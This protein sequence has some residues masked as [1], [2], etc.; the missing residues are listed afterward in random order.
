MHLDLYQGVDR[1]DVGSR[2]AHC[3]GEF[4]QPGWVLMCRID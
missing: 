1:L 3:A 4:R 2:G